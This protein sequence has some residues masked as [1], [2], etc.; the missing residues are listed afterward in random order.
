MF[1][2]KELPVRLSNC[3]KKQHHDVAVVWKHTL[4]K[5]KVT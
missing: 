3:T 1:M 4:N 2:L 5:A